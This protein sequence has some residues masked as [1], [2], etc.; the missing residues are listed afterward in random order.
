MIQKKKK[1]WQKTPKWLMPAAFYST[2]ILCCLLL[3][4]LINYAFNWSERLENFN[5]TTTNVRG[6]NILG[7][8]EVK[9]LANLPLAKSLNEINISNIQQRVEKHPYVK[10]ARISRSFPRK[11]TIDIVERQP[12]AYLNLPSFLVVDDEGFIMPLRHDNMEF[13][14]PTLTGFNPATELYPI[15]GKSLS[16]KTL[17][18]VDYLKI[19]RDLFPKLFEDISELTVDKEDAYVMV[20]SEYPTRIHFGQSDIIGQLMLLKEFDNMLS[21]L[22]SLNSYRYV[23]LRYKNQIVV[24]EQT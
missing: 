22:K 12:V 19:V 10:G 4:F 5:L 13:N 11:I 3:G 18:A 21:G 17:E 16:Y 8:D 2:A 7:H 15:G 9:A 23:D 14:I 6:N 20:L 24:R 1:P